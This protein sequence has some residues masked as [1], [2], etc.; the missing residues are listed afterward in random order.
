MP[1]KPTARRADPAA[2][3]P[4]TIL[5]SIAA[6]PETPASVRAWDLS[7]PDWADRLR[8]GKSL[9]PDLPHLN[10]A[11][12]DRAIALFDGLR[13]PDVHGLP[14]LE[15]A[16]GD[17]FREI[18][19]A[20]FGAVDPVTRERHIR[21][22][23][24]LAPKKSGKT[25]LGAATM[26]VALL[27]NTRPRAE[28]LLIAPTLMVADLCFAQCCGMAAAAGFLGKDADVRM[29]M[30]EHLRCL[31]DLDT[32]AKL[33]IKSFDASVL[34]G[35]RPAAVLVDELHEIARSPDARRIIGQLRGGLLSNPEAFLAFIST[36]SDMPPAGVF[37]SEL[38][39]ARATR[40]GKIS[41]DVLSVLYEF[42]DDMIQSGEWR[43]SK[44]WPMVTPNLGR[45]V[46]LDRLVTDW[47][48]AQNDGDEEIRRWASQHLN[49][50]VGLALRSDRWAGADFW[51]R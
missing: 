39:A 9:L 38:N 28:L 18:I 42:P 29:R 11:E 44:N 35:T 3:D 12:A 48:R 40:D 10:H 41:S 25:T 24:L 2:T 30:Q 1:K 34:T 20:L 46:T 33:R 19:R 36:Q 43:D 23:F 21:G 26:L 51:E 22:L 16:G 15:Q 32:G 27:M 6:D 13:L 7:R 14:K 49:L 47:E 45:S 37:R 17:W 4:R 5:R 31:T 50:E 8:A